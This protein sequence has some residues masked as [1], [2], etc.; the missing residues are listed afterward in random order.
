MLSDEQIKIKEDIT[1]IYDIKEGNTYSSS[2]KLCSTHSW[3][4]QVLL[5]F[6][7]SIENW[8]TVTKNVSKYLGRMMNI[9]E[10]WNWVHI[11]YY[12]Q[13]VA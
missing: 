8:K 9:V 7:N 10:I 2:L 5:Y 12:T 11:S 13:F 3:L 1:Q 6:D 4:K